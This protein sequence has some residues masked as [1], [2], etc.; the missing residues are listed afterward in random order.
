MCELG[1]EVRVLKWCSGVV[2]G[3]AQCGRQWWYVFQQ[4]QNV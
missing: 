1:G 4:C 3:G 2:C